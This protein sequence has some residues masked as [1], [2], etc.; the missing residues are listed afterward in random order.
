VRCETQC[1][2]RRL[3]LGYAR[4]CGSAEFRPAALP[5]QG[6]LV[7]AGEQAMG[8]VDENGGPRTTTTEIIATFDPPWKWDDLGMRLHDSPNGVLLDHIVVRSRAA[9]IDGLRIGIK[10][11]R[12]NRFFTEG[13]SMPEIRRIIRDRET[14]QE[15]LILKFENTSKVGSTASGAAMDHGFVINPTAAAKARD[16][17][18]AFDVEEGGGGEKK[19]KKEK[20]VSKTKT[21][22]QKRI[23]QLER[24][25]SLSGDAGFDVEEGVDR[26]ISVCAPWEAFIY[27]A[28]EQARLDLIQ[29]LCFVAT[30]NPAAFACAI[31]LCGAGTVAAD[32]KGDTAGWSALCID[33]DLP[34]Q[35]LLRN[36]IKCTLV[37]IPLGLALQLYE[38]LALPESQPWWCVWVARDE[39][40][41]GHLVIEDG[42]ETYLPGS[43]SAAWR[44]PADEDAVD[45][46][47]CDYY[48]ECPY[49]RGKWPVVY[50]GLAWIIML[51][52]LY[53][54]CRALA[55]ALKGRKRICAWA[56][57]EQEVRHQSAVQMQ[58]IARGRL[59]RKRIAEVRLPVC[60][61]LV[62]VH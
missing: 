62:C 43:Q 17:P 32:N 9:Q 35:V 47:V 50:I 51:M 42:Q 22:E 55:K 48:Q 4:Q 61:R 49:C 46:S 44:E 41:K 30:S 52:E 59:T 13:K 28:H 29:V 54:R 53:F 20:V 45:L 6:A 34:H 1:G 12:V 57:R 7:R 27:W 23:A 3:V 10:V 60:I 38:L 5:R 24:N 31:S 14:E 40:S 21:K 2:A 26:W 33:I 25:D 15:R 18:K 56:D 39:L 36:H 19:G 58:A 37:A 11:V 16:A 8:S